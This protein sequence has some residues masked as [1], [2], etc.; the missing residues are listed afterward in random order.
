MRASGLAGGCSCRKRPGDFSGRDSRPLADSIQRGVARRLICSFG[1]DALTVVCGGD[2]A[3]CPVHS[4][5]LHSAIQGLSAAACGR[6][7]S[8]CSDP[9][10][11]ISEI[12]MGQLTRQRLW[13]LAVTGILLALLIGFITLNS[14]RMTDHTRVMAHRGA[15]KSAPEN[16]LAAIGQAIEDGADWVEID[17]QET[18]DGH[19]VVMHDSDFMKIAGNL[20]KIW[21][22]TLDD[23]RS[24][25]IGSWFD[26]RF[27]D[28]SVSKLS[29]LLELCRGRV[30]VIIELKYYGHD[31]QL[32]Q[33]VFDIV[34]QAKMVDQ[35]NGHVAQA[36]GCPQD[37]SSEFRLEV[38]SAAVGL[39]RQLAASRGGFSGD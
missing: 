19:V 31:Q 32:E 7:P 12:A 38:R 15:S 24:I 3:Q 20:L 16:S 30:G 29:D 36:R 33:R 6:R 35:V 13:V 14:Y 23:L 22:A 18:L 4:C 1:A 21:D 27:A 34:E 25:G 10:C 5:L 39:R 11:R 8:D 26:P 2:V 37:Q 17:V 9:D 28:E